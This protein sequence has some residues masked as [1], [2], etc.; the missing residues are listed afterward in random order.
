MFS[1][2]ISGVLFLSQAGLFIKLLIDITL[3]CSVGG[4]CGG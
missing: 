1:V 2:A 3:T 4:H